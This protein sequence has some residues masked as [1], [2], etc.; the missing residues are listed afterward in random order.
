VPR[1]KRYSS[2]S[3]SAVLSGEVSPRRY[4]HLVTALSAT[5]AIAV[6]HGDVPTRRWVAEQ[7]LDLVGYTEEAELLEIC[8]LEP[9]CG[10]GAFLLP[11]VERLLSARQRDG[12][13]FAAVVDATPGVPPA[14]WKRSLYRSHARGPPR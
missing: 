9:S 12:R 3:G 6:N 8:L 13:D 5:P 7:I 14:A 2:A 4:C 10:R 1:L 11:A